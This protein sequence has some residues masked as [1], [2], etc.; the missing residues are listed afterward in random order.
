MS[1]TTAAVATRND[2]AMARAARS[3]FERRRG[4]QDTDVGEIGTLPLFAIDLGRIPPH[5]P[6]ERPAASAGWPGFAHARAREDGDHE[7]RR[8]DP[9]PAGPAHEPSGQPS[10]VG[11]AMPSPAA[12]RLSSRHGV[13]QAKLSVGTVD[14]PLEK[15][16]DQVAEK[17]L[18]M[19]DP[20]AAAGAP[21]APPEP[22]EPPA[23]PR[24]ARKCA[25]CKEED[26]E[27]GAQ[28]QR[29][30]EPGSSA[31]LPVAPPIVEQTLSGG[32]RPLDA[33][34][35][36]Y[37]EPRFGFDLS[38]VRVHTD[39]RAEA[40]ARA[41]N[42]L[43]YT[44][45]QHI[46]FGPG[47]YA[48]GQQEGRRLLAH[49]LAHVAQQSRHGTAVVRREAPKN[50]EE[51]L[52][53]GTKRIIQ[54][55]GKGAVL[56]RVFADHPTTFPDGSPNSK[57]NIKY[58][59][60]VQILER[61]NAL[62]WYLVKAVVDIGGGELKERIGFVNVKYLAPV[63]AAPAAE[64]KAPAQEPLKSPPAEPEGWAEVFKKYA[65]YRNTYGTFEKVNP[66]ERR[67]TPFEAAAQKALTEVLDQLKT[68][69]VESLDAFEEQI[70]KRRIEFEAAARARAFRHLDKLK[71]QLVAEQTRYG[72]DEPVTDLT[73]ALAKTSARADYKEADY[74][75]TEAEHLRAGGSALM[76]AT[77][78]HNKRK[79]EELKERTAAA[80]GGPVEFL[81]PDARM[82][83]SAEIAKK[84]DAA[85]ES[86]GDRHPLVRYPDFPK[87]ELGS[88][89]A[90]KIRSVL[91][92]YITEHIAA[93]DKMRKRIEGDIDVVYKLD[94]LIEQTYLD[95]NGVKP[96]S[97]TDLI[98]QQRKVELK[99]LTDGIEA[100]I[101]LMTVAL[102]VVTLGGGGVVAAGVA[103]AV[104]GAGAA[105]AAYDYGNDSAAYAAQLSSVPP[106]AMWVLI[107]LVMLGVDAALAVG[108]VWPKVAKLVSAFNAG[109]KPLAE[110]DAALTALVKQG[111]I[112]DVARRAILAEASAEAA[113][114]AAVSQLFGRVKDVRRLA[115]LLDKVKDPAKLG[116]LLDKVGDAAKLETLLQTRTAAEVE[117]LSAAE[118]EAALKQAAA[119]GQNIAGAAHDTRFRGEPTGP[120]VRDPDL[121][122]YGPWKLNPDGKVLSIP[123]ALEQAKK[124]GVE[125]P[126]WVDFVSEPSLAKGKLNPIGTD[127]SLNPA[128]TD[129]YARYDFRIDSA[130]VTWANLTTGG[131]I[132]VSVRPDVFN[133]REAVTAIFAHEVHELVSLH[134]IFENV[135]R[136]PAKELQSLI[137]AGRTNLHFQAWDVADLRVLLMRAEG[138]AA[139]VEELLKRIS[140]QTARHDAEL[141]RIIKNLE[142][143]HAAL[144]KRTD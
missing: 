50:A 93:V 88:A 86:V 113:H 23:D 125:I 30:A 34:A 136:V 68:I 140:T 81:T 111:E 13:L 58:G 90:E 121:V 39:A 40:S 96:G 78:E 107:S 74:Q 29:R 134:T 64:A 91:Q 110:L 12:G 128:I 19:P 21:E 5:P 9:A 76:M 89:P 63:P 41:V 77:P 83:K 25:A 95:L 36:A 18:R 6:G 129:T 2:L 131:K 3:P 45:G 126:S 117:K 123:E 82:A 51:D 109:R 56:L 105:K 11:W 141:E 130:H 102:T 124:A 53:P 138:D 79:L 15:E 120:N 10:L 108:A 42:A 60:E 92:T 8:R 114:R 37:F 16:A 101:T 61:K 115:A 49:E 20:A 44:V 100:L 47:R 85:V 31:G 71:E 132:K 118:L 143:G 84:G 35:R 122:R 73:E 46:V 4:A 55:P 98:V 116:Q 62:G 142:E 67:G 69:N 65:A 33:G 104:S 99:Q 17:V 32:G 48:P 103:V 87:H 57:G 70:K 1:K 52:P 66:S 133:S 135:E 119:D 27:K 28:V 22:P 72:S 137:T 139:K 38:K 127:P 80:N 54:T 97:L 24:L 106:D 14:D 144:A 7:A 75:R 94:K 59:T 43:A 26:E 112:T